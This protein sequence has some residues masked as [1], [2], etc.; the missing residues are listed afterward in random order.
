MNVYIET[1]F[2][3][4]MAL[5]QGDCNVCEKLVKLCE[6]NELS[7]IIPA[8]SLAEPYET[9]TRRHRDRKRLK[10]DVERELKQLART[11]PYAD[12][13]RKSI[14]S[15]NLLIQSTQEETIRLEET[16]SRL[17]KIAHTIPLTSNILK[18]AT[19]Y[20]KVHDLSPQDAVVYASVLHHLM[21]HQP[22]KTSCFLNKNSKD[23]DD[24]DI[25]ETLV[26]YDCIMLSKFDAGY[27][28]ITNK[29]HQ[30]KSV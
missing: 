10:T 2:V 4:E 16:Q 13:A 7:L 19:Q 6:S 21:Q 8:Y 22:E 9:L 12:S 29:M 23:F 5:L 15:L 17:I 3:L 28:F 14:I 20:Q 24:P 1:N 18:S 11:E 26:N 27:Q 25:V 30:C